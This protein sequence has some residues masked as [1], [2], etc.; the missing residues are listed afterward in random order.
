[1]IVTELQT[2]A[3]E[4]QQLAQR[5]G[6][7]DHEAFNALF[8]RYR[9]GIYRFCL[10]MLGDAA[11]AE[12]VYQ[13]VFLNFYRACRRGQTMQSVRGYLVAS[14][15]TRCLNDIRLATR[16]TD[17]SSLTEPSY[18]PDI[19]ASDTGEHLRLALQSIQPQYR[20][21][22]LLFEYEGYSYDEIAR[23][24]GITNDVV[25]NRIYRAKQALQKILR[26]LLRG[27]HPDED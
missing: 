11:A 4:E 10:L 25:K 21:A 13:E 5:A 24:L 26:P 3:I 7:G 17:F 2:R 23:Q 16:T 1:V 8:E 9:T 19:A 18:E 14:A 22:F 20:E 15:R 12:D 27:E 6:E